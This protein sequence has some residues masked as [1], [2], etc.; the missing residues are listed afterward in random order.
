MSALWPFIIIGLTTGSVYSLL[1]VGLV[2]TYKTSGIFN[3]AQGSVAAL[4]V[5]FF[6]FLHD[7][8]G[9]AWPLTAVLVVFV[10]GPVLGLLLE[11]V[12]RALDP[13]PDTLKVVGTVGLVLSVLAIGGLWYGTNENTFESFLPTKAYDVLG[14]NVGWDQTIVILF[15]LTCTVGLAY[16]LKRV[17][18]GVSMRG[19]VDNPEL[20]NITGQSSLRIRRYA[21]IIG[22]MFACASGILIAPGLSLDA[23]ILTLLVVQAFGAAAIGYFSSLPLTYVGGLVVG[24]AG[25]LTTH[26]VV[27]FPSLEGLPP[28]IPFIVLFLV[29]LVTPKARLAARRVV[30]TLPV[31]K[32][33]YFPI[34][35][36]LLAGAVFI[37]VLAFIPDMV[38]TYLSVW[39]NALADIILFFS[40]GILVR[41]SGQISLC[42]YAFAA[43]GA[44]AMGHFAGGFGIPWLLALLLSGLV[45]VPIGAILAIPAIRL[46]GVFL[47]LATFG[48]G[49]LLEQM[50]YT[51]NFM[52][53]SNTQGLA[54][55]RPDISIG[56]W[57]LYTDRGFYYVLLICMLAAVAFVLAVQ[58][59][60]L[61]RLLR[62]L[63]DSPLALGTQGATVNVTRVIIFCFS[64]FLAAIAGALLT[65]LYHFGVGTEFDSLQSLQLLAL[66]VLAV[67]GDPWYPIFGAVGVALLP[68]Y[69]SVNNISL[70]LGLFFGAGA[71]TFAFQFQ[72]GK[73]P[74]VPSWLRR[75]GD[76]LNVLL[77]GAQPSRPVVDKTPAPGEPQR[78][79]E[80][81]LAAPAS[82]RDATPPERG[83][84]IRE[85]TVRYGGAV[86]VDDL[87]IDVPLATITGLI[88]PNG[89]GKTTTFNA[90]CGLLRPTRGHILFEG[91]D[92]SNLGPASRARL[93]IGRTF[94]RVELFNS[95]TVRENVE[96]G[97]EA[98]LA[99]A[100][101]LHQ[102]SGRRSDRALVTEA[103]D[104][105][106]A[107]TGIGSLCNLQAG[108]LPTGQRRL[109][110]LARALAG[111]FDL[112][113][114]DEPSSGLDANETQRFGEIIAEV[115]GERGTGILLVEHD[116]S[117]VYQVCTH[118]YV[119]DTGQ[120]IFEGT[121]DE[122]RESEAVRAAYLGGSV[123]AVLAT[124]EAP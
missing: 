39:S 14:V 17:R 112:L 120:K 46:S 100:N 92:I 22:S 37:L 91:R 56:G 93:G 33:Y 83:L 70:Y 4:A 71:A 54:T 44:A 96:L 64:A 57:H 80:R 81:T 34:R 6:Y 108:L 67:I 114:L 8:H 63:A 30:T 123:E 2:L 109:V 50:F 10:V 86:A 9:L 35:V 87:S 74:S 89:A 78:G 61:G 104:R 25:A 55:P 68:A 88:G 106:V 60:R 20:M 51:F 1:A 23:T 62:A 21:W 32:S 53:G 111:P 77:G 18:L 13:V 65:A 116:M 98:T 45:A 7:Q 27:D 102:I 43:V 31:Q 82:H 94:Q 103:V 79:R 99:G 117:L 11:L 38:G 119:M 115:V 15:S 47:A 41:L 3:F 122:M 101:P 40:L 85:L 42:Q 124:G 29:L 59:S 73:L 26:F 5:F 95:L 97:R 113:L 121:P 90:C 118:V 28:G 52:F 48:F 16:F 84:E 19:V 76:R 58:H 49:I 110:E 66:V 75:A 72:R 12:G 69:I 107:L 24:I 36:R 105:A